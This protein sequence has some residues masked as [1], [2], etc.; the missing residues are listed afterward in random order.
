[1]SSTYSGVLTWLF[2]PWRIGTVADDR[3]S[4]LRGSDWAS[5]LV[6]E[7]EVSRF[8]HCRSTKERSRPDI[9]DR[10]IRGDGER[11]SVGKSNSHLSSPIRLISTDIRHSLAY[12]LVTCKYNHYST[13]FIDLL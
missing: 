8:S 4:V 2:E 7:V 1:V 9:L 12:E 3:P 6:V 10:L 5:S 11:M 13:R